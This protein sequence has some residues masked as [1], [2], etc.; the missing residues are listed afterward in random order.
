MI[1]RHDVQPT[2]KISVHTGTPEAVFSYA[3]VWEFPSLLDRRGSST[4]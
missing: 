4:E 2:L 1:G 3:E